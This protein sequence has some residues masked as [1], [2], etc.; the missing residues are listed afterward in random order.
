MNFS[1]E[2]EPRNYQEA[3][4]QQCWHD[5]MR[6]E[7]AA[8]K[9]N[10]TWEIVDTLANVKPIGCKWVYKIKRNSDGSVERYKARLVAKGFSQVEGIDFFETFSPIVKMTTVHVILALASIYRWDLQQ[11]DVSNAFLHGDLSEEVYMSIPPG[12]QGHG[13]PRCCKSK[14]SLYGLKQASRKWYE[15]F[16]TLLMSSGYQQ[17]HS[18]HSLFV[19]HYNGT[20]TALLIYVDDIVLTGNSLTE[21]A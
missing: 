3:I 16:S 10:N 17:A 19:K 4:S 8:L 11:L 6:D 14:K 5:A 1:S 2:I 9:L 18:D 7:I 12:L 21:M 13:S 15:K 20:I